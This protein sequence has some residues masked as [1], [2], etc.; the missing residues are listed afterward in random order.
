M[1]IN[2]LGVEFGRVSWTCMVSFIANFLESIIT[3]LLIV[4]GLYN[5]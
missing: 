1:K 5:I 3:S 4:S 2:A